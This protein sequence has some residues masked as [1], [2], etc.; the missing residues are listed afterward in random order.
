MS[1]TNENSVESMLNVTKD[2]VKQI[3]YIFGDGRSVLSLKEFIHL[4][5][6]IVRVSSSFCLVEEEKSGRIT[7]QQIS[8]ALTHAGF[9]L[10]EVLPAL[11]KC[12]DPDNVGSFDFMMFFRM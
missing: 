2:D 9:G 5:K 6:F 7:R 3:M 8:T 1:F 4:D 12:H 11:F 10:D